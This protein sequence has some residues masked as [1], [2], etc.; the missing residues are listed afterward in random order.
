MSPAISPLEGKP[1]PRIPRHRRPLF[2]GMDTHALSEPAFASA[3][4]VFAANGVGTMIDAAG[5]YTP[6]PVI[7][8]AIL[9]HNKGRETGLADG[10]VISPSHNPPQDGGFKYNP[11]NGGP[12]EVE[13]IDW[14]GKTANEFI[15]DRLADV[16][17]MPLER[18]RKA[19]CIHA[20]DFVTA[21]VSD[22]DRVVDME[23]VR[24]SGST[25]WAGPQLATGSPYLRL[26]GASPSIVGSCEMP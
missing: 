17:R 16:R 18:A 15:T 3:L 2:V 1:A 8:H 7:S 21:Y 4:K 25:P 24:G 5:G 19:A 11:P 13:V 26:L 10:V 9:T 23:L 20:F 6:T 12:A 14:I 22:L